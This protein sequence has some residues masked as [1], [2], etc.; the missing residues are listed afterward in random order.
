MPDIHSIRIP[1]PPLSEQD[2]IVEAAWSR[3]RQ[4]DRLVTDV[5]RQVELLQEHR[6]ALITAAVTGELQIPERVA[7]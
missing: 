1:L 4:V 5:E 2:E 3:F 6:Q 7:K